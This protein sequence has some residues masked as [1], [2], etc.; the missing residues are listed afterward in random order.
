MT[1][2]LLENKPDGPFVTPTLILPTQFI[3]FDSYE[4]WNEYLNPNAFNLAGYKQE[5][6][7]AIQTYLDGFVQTLWY[8]SMN[9]VPT[10]NVVGGNWEL[11]AKALLLWNSR[12]WSDLDVYYQ[13]S[14]TEANKIAI[15]TY[16]NDIISFV[17][18]T[19]L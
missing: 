5:L 2:Y 10:C 14:I 18:F 7:Q 12:V 3:V 17:D 13:T 11:E 1:T 19:N 6:T 8:D 4:E 9:E 16:V 15:N